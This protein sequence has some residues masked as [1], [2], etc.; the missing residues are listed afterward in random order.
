MT[1][2]KIYDT[3]TERRRVEDKKI[4]WKTEEREKEKPGGGGGGNDRQKE[5]K[6]GWEREGERTCGGAFGRDAGGNR[7]EATVTNKSNANI[8]GV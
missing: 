3:L 8:S 5:V 1:T 7:W 6:E 2:R 4:E